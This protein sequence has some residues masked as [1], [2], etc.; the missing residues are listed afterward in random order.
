MQLDWYPHKEGAETWAHQEIIMKMKAE[1]KWC[2]LSQTL[3]ADSK[4]SE[5]GLRYVAAFSTHSAGT[6]SVML[7]AQ[8]SLLQ[9]DETTI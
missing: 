4:P 6:N 5:Q 8:P 9:G 1:I 3:K 7:P 2:S